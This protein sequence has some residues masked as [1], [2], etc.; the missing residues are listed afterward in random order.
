MTRF[1]AAL[2]ALALAAC[3]QPEQATPALWE[4]TGPDGQHGYLFGTIHALD[5]EVDWRSD[6]LDEAFE[7]SNTL[8]VEAA[9]IA[10]AEAN[11][12]TWRLLAITPGQPPLTQR[13]PAED[14]AN[15]RATLDRLSY[16]EN[17]FRD[18]E[19]WAAALGL[20]SGLRDEDGAA[21]DLL[22]MRDAGTKRIVELEGVAGQLAIFDILP[23][24]DQSALLASVADGAVNDPGGPARLDR[25]WRAGD[26]DALAAETRR[27]ML[28]D[29][30]LREALLVG[31]NRA[32]T[33]RIEAL[34][35][36]GARP[37]VAVGAAHLAGPDGLPKML[38]ERGYRVTRIE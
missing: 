20:A 13:V 18:V 3:A 24:E 15:L 23:P 10:N 27:G 28:A 32:W 29:P 30:E 7:A 2:V 35:K 5:E 4:V 22:L 25:L 38:E 11:A 33:G 8:V 37:F 12:R 31:R 16:D 6:A 1:L 36:G 21:V 9:G 19:T 26:I 34:L 17:E 14:A